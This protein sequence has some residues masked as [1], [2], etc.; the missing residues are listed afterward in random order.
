M[1]NRITTGHFGIFAKYKNQHQVYI[2]ISTILVRNFSRQNLVIYRFGDISLKLMTFL[3][4]KALSDS[5]PP[6]AFR[7]IYADFHWPISKYFSPFP[8]CYFLGSHSSDAPYSNQ[9]FV[10]MSVTV[11]VHKTCIN[12]ILQILYTYMST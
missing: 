9:S 5:S 8:N 1:P 3:T 12:K 11:F 6:S 4:E 7:G 10:C 2:R